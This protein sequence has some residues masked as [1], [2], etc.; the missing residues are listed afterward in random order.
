[1]FKKNDMK[2]GNLVLIVEENLPTNKWPEL[3]TSFMV[4][5][6][7]LQLYPYQLKMEYLKHPFQKFVY[8][9]CQ[10]IIKCVY[11]LYY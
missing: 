9:P 2:T 3:L 5:V 11:N 8:Y 10:K 4:K 7:K 1:M 6:E